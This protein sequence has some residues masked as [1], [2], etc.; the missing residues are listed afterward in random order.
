MFALFE[1]YIAQVKKATETVKKMALDF[2]R[3]GRMD[4]AKRALEHVKIM[5]AEVA[6][7]EAATGA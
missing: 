2:R 3:L 6:E 5:T 4:L 7:V 1:G